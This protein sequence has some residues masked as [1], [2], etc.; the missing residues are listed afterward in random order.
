MVTARWNGVVVAESDSTVI[1]EGN[2]YFPPDS[3]SKD[4][5]ITNDRT[6]VCPWKGTASYYDLVVDG[7]VNSA[8]A[9]TYADPSSAAASI[10]DHVA[11]YG[12]V[13]ITP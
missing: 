1:V 11:F 4:H 3:I 8:A 5:F 13:D 9:W 10:K 7:Q 12:S 6:T 2:L